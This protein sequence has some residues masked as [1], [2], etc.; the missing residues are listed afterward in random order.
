MDLEIILYNFI[1]NLDEKLFMTLN[2][3]CLS[4]FHYRTEK[5]QLKLEWQNSNYI[6]YFE[7]SRSGFSCSP[8]EKK[9]LSIFTL[10]IFIHTL[11]F[12]QERVHIFFHSTIGISLFW[13]IYWSSCLTWKKTL[14]WQLSTINQSSLISTS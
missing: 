8:Y 14:L 1:S 7:F 5:M 11:G 3:R 12:M 2:F 10:F 4:I 6:W 9:I 13:H